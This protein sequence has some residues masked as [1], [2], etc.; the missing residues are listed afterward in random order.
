MAHQFHHDPARWPKERIVIHSTEEIPPF[1]NECEE[2]E[3]WATHEPGAELFE[4]AQPDPGLPP[5]RP[6][7]RMRSGR[8]EVYKDSQGEYRWRLK[9]SNGV[10]IAAS[11]EGYAS[12]T[13]AERAIEAVKTNAPGATV[14]RA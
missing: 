7:P 3:F 5:P 4:D 11:G 12:P 2:H 10:V 14:V 8:F 6:R 1:T 9:S 13:A